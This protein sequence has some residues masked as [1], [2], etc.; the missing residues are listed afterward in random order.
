[1][2][3]DV[4]TKV[5]LDRLELE[6][7]WL[8]ETSPGNFQAGYLLDRPISDS[9]VVDAL[10][11]SVIAANLCDP[12]AGG[13]TARLARLPVG[14]NGKHDPAFQCRLAQWNPALRYSVEDLVFGFDL[15][16]RLTGTAQGR[17]ARK[18]RR[19][20]RQEPEDAELFI[21]AS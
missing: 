5:P 6:P 21:A 17:T 15:D 16:L 18:W 3:D 12:G 19:R 1:M 20:M 10:M 4:G 14:V 2:L 7:S 13:P 8:L 9:K 11:K